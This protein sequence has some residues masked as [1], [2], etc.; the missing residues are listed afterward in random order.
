MTRT[1][2]SCGAEATGSVCEYCGTRIPEKTVELADILGN[3]AT[4]EALS[5]HLIPFTAT[6]KQA[7]S[8]VHQ[9]LGSIQ[10][11]IKNEL[12]KLGRGYKGISLSI[13]ETNAVYVPFNALKDADKVTSIVCNA[14]T[15]DLPQGFP[16]SLSGRLWE[17]I[18]NRVFY[19]D[20][21]S[22]QLSRASAVV[23][24]KEG[25]PTNKG[26]DKFITVGETTYLPFWVIMGQIGSQ[27]FRAFVLAGCRNAPELINI[28]TTDGDI[29]NLYRKVNNYTYSDFEASVKGRKEKHKKEVAKEEKRSKISNVVMWIIILLGAA[30]G[31]WF[32]SIMNSYTDTIGAILLGGIL[33]VVGGGIGFLISLIFCKFD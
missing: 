29:K 19:S 9:K 28:I 30:G 21:I 5:I 14:S 4:N 8:A 33:A 25:K 16:T 11:Q 18:T 1:C 26:N 3:G 2:P 23:A 15:K 10:N 17:K 27:T 24:I 22:R 31:V 13:T 6:E 20:E 12:S 32:G 7:V